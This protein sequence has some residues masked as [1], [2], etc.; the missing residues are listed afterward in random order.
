MKVLVVLHDPNTGGGTERTALLAAAELRDHGH[1][2][3]LLQGTT[4]AA[5]AGGFDAELREPALFDFSVRVPR[6]DVEAATAR[7]REHVAAHDV[8]LVHVHSFPNVGV[9]R[10][11]AA[12]RPVV[13]TAHNVACP[14]GARYQWGTGHA[15]EREIG[16]AC[17]TTGY[18]SLGCGHL[19]NGAP[20]SLPGF[21]FAMAVDA[22][23]RR[24]LRTADAVVAPSAWMRG[25]LRGEGVDVSR[26]SVVEPPIV[27]A[28][29]GAVADLEPVDLEPADLEPTDLPRAQPDDVPVVTFVGRLVEIKGVD[30]LLRASALT[31]VPHRL[32]IAGDGGARAELQALAAELGV[33]E[34]TTF[35]GAVTPAEAT[36]LRRRSAVV[37][38][39]SVVPETFG[40]V[41]PEALLAGVPVV[42]HDFAGTS[43]W[44]AAAGPLARGVPPRDVPAFAAAMT[45]LLLDPPPASVRERVAGAMRARYSLRRHVQGVLD[46]YRGVVGAEPVRSGEPAA[47]V[48]VTRRSA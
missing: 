44:I 11:L 19:G 32:V 37:A 8:D 29:V 36:R 20:M 16:L 40:M 4:T 3:H 6:K 23:I 15:C 13:V 24:E 9:R 7:V 22:R 5:P 26:L 31:P 46:A 38:V 43:G 18:R 47:A 39:P 17:L 28:G 10:S 14:N 41:G 33:L 27:V 45:E 21:G 2:V 1:E 34:R 25:H 12:G 35:L 42:A 30:V 48:V